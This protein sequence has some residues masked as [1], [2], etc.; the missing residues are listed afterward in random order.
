MTE[1]YL[2]RHGQTNSNIQGT[3]LGHTDVPL[4]ENGKQQAADAAEQFKKIA[5]NAIYTSPLIRAVQTAQEVSRYHPKISVTM[6]YDVQERDYGV[7][8]DLTQ[9][10]IQKQYPDQYQTWMRQWLTYQIPE[11][12]SAEDVHL[13]VKR[14]FERA[15]DAHMGQKILIVTHLGVARHM[16]SY[17][18]GLDIQ[19]SWHFSLENGKYAHISVTDEKYGVLKGLNLK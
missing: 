10:Q 1:F 12:E 14:F 4:N 7:F 15:I 6:S 16:M 8:D 17:L 9:K 2:L 13:R 19:E 18:L 3:Y 11:G 5:L